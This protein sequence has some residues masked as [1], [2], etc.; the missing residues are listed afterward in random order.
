MDSSGS[1]RTDAGTHPRARRRVI[2]LDR[3]AG[4]QV[5]RT[6]VGHP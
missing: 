1:R 6:T 5:W 3:A 4:F 2:P